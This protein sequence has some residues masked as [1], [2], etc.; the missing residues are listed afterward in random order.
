MATHKGFFKPLNPDKY[1][2]DPTNI[3]YRSRWEAVL[4]ARLD[5]DPNVIWWQSEE[6]VIPYRSPVDKRI[7]RYFVDFQIQ[8]QQ[9]DGNLK[10]Y[11]VE[12][13]PS[14]QCAPPEYPGKQTKRYIT[15]SLT[16]IKNEAKWKAAREYCKD[17]GWEFKI[18]TEVE[19]GL[20]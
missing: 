1:K 16:Y 5:K 8:V 12:I 14:K 19:L 17:R 6:T 7:H 3:I 10:R 20:K 11:L 2:G 13:K 18:I 9:R 4:M 15:E